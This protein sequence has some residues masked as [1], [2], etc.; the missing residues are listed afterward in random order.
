MLSKLQLTKIHC[1]CMNFYPLL[2]LSISSVQQHFAH[3]NSISK[4]LWFHISVW[5]RFEGQIGY[6]KLEFT[7]NFSIGC[8]NQNCWA[9]NQ[10]T[11]QLI[12]ARISTVFCFYSSKFFVDFVQQNKRLFICISNLWGN[13]SSLNIYTNK[14]MMIP[15][16]IGLQN[17]YKSLSSKSLMT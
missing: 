10:K 7:F 9:F 11:H 5:N 4:S 1:C 13:N 3:F 6:M 15:T 17:S 12:Q 14:E 16:A 2:L 8:R